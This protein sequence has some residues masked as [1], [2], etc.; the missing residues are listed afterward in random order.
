MG[1]GGVVMGAGG[2]LWVMGVIMGAG[3]ALWVLGGSL[4]VLGEHCG[5]WGGH[6]GAL[7]V[8]PPLTMSSS[9]PH[10]PSTN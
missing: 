7:R 8:C 4:W 1:D 10:R 6:W 3:V 2:A 9:P 5:R